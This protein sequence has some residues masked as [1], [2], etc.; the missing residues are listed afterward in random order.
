MRV[1]RTALLTVLIAGGAVAPGY[2]CDVV[3][4]AGSYP[5][6]Y[7]DKT[8]AILLV[9]AI[10]Y[11]G[12][13]RD[14]EYDRDGVPK[15]RVRFSVLETLKGPWIAE[16][17]L[18]GFLNDVDDIDTDRALAGIIR[19]PSCYRDMYRQG[20]TFLLLLRHVADGEYTTRFA[21]LRPTNEQVRPLDDPWV[22]FVRRRLQTRPR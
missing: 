22:R 18:P 15:S 13:A 10:A 14:P 6:D 11:T 19:S 12:P 21:A 2:P 17:V 7:I 4:G 5:F 16:V 20:G 1:P 8:D 3:A 9:K